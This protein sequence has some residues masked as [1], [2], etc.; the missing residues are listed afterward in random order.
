MQLETSYADQIDSGP[1]LSPLPQNVD[2]SPYDRE[3]IADAVDI[4]NPNQTSPRVRRRK[5]KKAVKYFESVDLED[6]DCDN[7]NDPD[8]KLEPNTQE[9]LE[10]EDNDDMDVADDVDVADNVDAA[11][12]S[13]AAS[14]AKRADSP[15]D[16]YGAS[17]QESNINTHKKVNIGGTCIPGASATNS[18]KDNRNT[19]ELKSSRDPWSNEDIS[20]EVCGTTRIMSSLSVQEDE[21]DTQR[22]KEDGNCFPGLG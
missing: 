3:L 4:A 17:D 8:F 19:E 20:R 12:D 21:K 6:A 10:S 13:D 18:A 2:R 14:E 1:E 7:K 15:A 22:E 9:D 11:D 16:L 5:A